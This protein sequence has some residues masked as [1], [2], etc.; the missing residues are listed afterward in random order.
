MKVCAWFLRWECRRAASGNIC[1]CVRF[2]L[3]I[4]LGSFQ[5][6]CLNFH[7]QGLND[8][9]SFSRTS[10]K[11]DTLLIIAC[12]GTFSERDSQ[13]VRRGLLSL[14]NRTCP[15]PKQLAT[16]SI[17]M[18]KLISLFVNV[19]SIVQFRTNFF[20]TET[21]LGKFANFWIFA[22]FVLKHFSW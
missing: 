10:L 8:H 11:F 12:M 17:K 14:E 18:S 15:S 4:K 22:R 9:L 13:K 6:N 5:N 3:I 19:R 7:I 1:F 2:V 21:W 16:F 20:A